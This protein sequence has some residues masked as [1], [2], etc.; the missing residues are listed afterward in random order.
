MKTKN[1]SIW[2]EWF[3]LILGVNVMSFLIGLYFG[4]L[5]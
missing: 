4:G 1:K 2:F 5:I 3:L